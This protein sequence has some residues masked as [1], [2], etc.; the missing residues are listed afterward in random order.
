MQ[1]RN[2]LLENAGELRL[3][4]ELHNGHRSV[5]IF[6]IILFMMIMYNNNDFIMMDEELKKSI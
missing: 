1:S 3:C 2:Y 6:S 4:S 5:V